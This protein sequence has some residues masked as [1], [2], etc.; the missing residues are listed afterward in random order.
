[1]IRF[2]LTKADFLS[3]LVCCSNYE[4]IPPEKRVQWIKDSFQTESNLEIQVLQY[5]EEELPNTS[6]ASRDVSLL[7]SKKFKELYPDYELVITSEEYGDYVA[8]FMEIEHIAFDIPRNQYPVSA[9]AIRSNRLKYWEFLPDSVKPD[10]A[11]KVVILGTESTG[12]TTLANQLADYFQCSVV[13]ETGR[14]LIAH[15]DTVEY[16][17]LEQVAIEHANRIEQ[18]T[19][20][21][22]PLIIVDTDIHIT[23]SYARFL[24]GRNLNLP[25][26]FFQINKA[27]LYLYCTRDVPFVQ[28]GSRL[29]EEQRNKLDQSHRAI[30]QSYGI[31]FTE[32]TGTWEDRFKD[33]VETVDLLIGS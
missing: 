18:A 11:F 31:T 10:F 5:L 1:M 7:W 29:K 27:D 8:G 22:H 12:K 24:F 9:S 33:A 17:Q 14:E 16:A 23:I 28:D 19:K 15:S 32:L 3:V 20:G 26:S 2:A 4:Q 13:Q 6:A 25:D 30:L 21:P